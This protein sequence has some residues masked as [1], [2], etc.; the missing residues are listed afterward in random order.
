MSLAH[1]DLAAV[2]R[3]NYSSAPFAVASSK[4]PSVLSAAPSAS[5]TH[6]SD[7]V[8]AAFAVSLNDNPPAPLKS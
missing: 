8:A 3:L 7:P 4:H 2:Q 5:W 6:S 1:A